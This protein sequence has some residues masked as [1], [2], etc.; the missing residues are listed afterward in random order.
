MGNFIITLFLVIL[1]VWVCW[2]LCGN[3]YEDRRRQVY[4][5]LKQPDESNE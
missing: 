1:I 3:G 2:A 4:V 5:L